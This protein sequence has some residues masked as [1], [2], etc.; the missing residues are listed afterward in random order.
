MLDNDTEDKIISI[1][2]K[3]FR[4][5]TIILIAH[6]LSTVKNADIIYVIDNGHVGES[7]THEELLNLIFI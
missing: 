4:D 5:R 2:L 7:G 3:S 1:L 6:R